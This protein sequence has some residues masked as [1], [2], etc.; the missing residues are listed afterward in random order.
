[1]PEG[2]NYLYRVE[3][4]TASYQSFGS[5]KVGVVV[6][7][8][9]LAKFA[10]RSARLD[11]LNHRIARTS[12]LLS[13]KHDEVPRGLQSFGRINRQRFRKAGHEV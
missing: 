8:S 11:D 10:V 5:P 7:G 6:V 3:K 4:K 12:N 2:K 9:L 1:M 13:R